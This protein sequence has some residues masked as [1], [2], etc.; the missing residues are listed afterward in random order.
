M[1]DEFIKLNV[2]DENFAAK[3]FDIRELGLHVEVSQ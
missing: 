1:T 2:N 3:V